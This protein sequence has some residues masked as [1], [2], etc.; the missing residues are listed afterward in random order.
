MVTT[1][2]IRNVL[3]VYGNQLKRKG[4]QPPV[5]PG[6]SQKRADSVDIS[7]EARRKQILNQMSNRLITQITTNGQRQ[8]AEVGVRGNP[9]QGLEVLA[10]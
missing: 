2:Q 10:F 5:D 9:S 6:Q 3:R 8:N 4:A 7:V 1:Y